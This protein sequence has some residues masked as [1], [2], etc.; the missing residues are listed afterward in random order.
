[1]STM[2]PFDVVILVAVV[3]AVALCVRYLVRSSRNGCSDCASA[4]SCNAYATGGTCKAANDMLRNVDA[5][6]SAKK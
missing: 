4:S 3:A 1:M 6:F 5:A 2:T